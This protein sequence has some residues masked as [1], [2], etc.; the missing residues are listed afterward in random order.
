M[1]SELSRQKHEGETVLLEY[2][3]DQP[4]E[5][6]LKGD[7]EDLRSGWIATSAGG[8]LFSSGCLILLI[9]ARAWLLEERLLLEVKL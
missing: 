4:S 9:V 7:T 8:V 1:S 6:R 2:G 5:V 3:R